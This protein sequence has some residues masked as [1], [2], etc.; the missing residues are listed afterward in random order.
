M[1]NQN[2]TSAQYV[3]IDAVW[4]RLGAALR[5][6]RKESGLSVREIERRSG[7][8]RR[9]LYAYELAENRGGIELKKLMA[10]CSAIG[11]DVCELLRE[12]MA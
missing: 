9:T 2:A 11:C 12:A 5:K 6:R 4:E 8:T 1:M 7:V 3:V 10:L